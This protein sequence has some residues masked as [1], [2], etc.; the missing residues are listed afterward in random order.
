MTASF[1][2]RFDI[3]LSAASDRAAT[4]CKG[5]MGYTFTKNPDRRAM[6]KRRKTEEIFQPKF[7]MLRS[8]T[9]IDVA[10]EMNATGWHGL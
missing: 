5:S 2:V 9:S 8:K 7:R 4:A 10:S 3:Y 6:G 1:C